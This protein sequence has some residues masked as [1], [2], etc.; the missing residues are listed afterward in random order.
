MNS[1][2]TALRMVPGILDKINEHE[3]SKRELLWPEPSQH[4]SA[5]SRCLR[6]N[7]WTPWETSL[8]ILAQTLLT[9]LSQG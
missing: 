9:F 3:P 6:E 5:L 4:E 7:S 8:L 1:H 2:R